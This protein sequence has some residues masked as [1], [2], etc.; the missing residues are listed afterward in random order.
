MYIWCG[1]HEQG[2]AFCAGVVCV[3]SACACAALLPRF[4]LLS[5]WFSIPASVEDLTNDGALF[6]VL[7]VVK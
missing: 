7:C 2:H 1:V 6:R 4:S 5:S 3:L